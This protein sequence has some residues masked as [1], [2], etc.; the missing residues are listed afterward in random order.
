MDGKLDGQVAI[1]TG[2][3]RGAGAAIAMKLAADGAAVV[4]NDLDEAPASETAEAIVEAGGRALAVAGDVTES[5]FGERIVEATLDEF[6][7]LHI[8]VNNAGYIWNTAIQNTVDEQWDAM[9]EVH[10][11][12]PFRLLRAAYPHIREAAKREREERGAPLCRKVV[13]ISSVSGLYGA[14]T[15]IAYSAGKAAQIGITRTLAKE[16]GRYNVTVN[17]VAF[18]H[19][20]T[21]LTQPYTDA[22]A[23]IEVKGR[24][25][26]VGLTPDFLETIRALTPLGRPGTPEDA[27][28]AVSLFCYPESNYISGQVVV[29]G[30]GL[31]L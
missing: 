18:G 6:G 2:G 10:A 13:N 23:T 27:A 25:H 4:V 19:I 26:K 8:L 30:G 5:G 28:G 20:E 14:A 1:V 21:R 24:P 9:L 29:C 11:G 16:W 3:G 15:Q 12:A 22:P 31:L 17:C 7:D